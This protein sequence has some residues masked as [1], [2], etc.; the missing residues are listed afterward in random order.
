MPWFPARAGMKISVSTIPAAAKPSE[1]SSA[2]SIPWT[3]AA[4]TEASSDADFSARATA[5]P[6]NTLR[7]ARLDGRSC[8]C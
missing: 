7:R 4:R 1:T 6:P 3:N 2:T 5:T 8:A